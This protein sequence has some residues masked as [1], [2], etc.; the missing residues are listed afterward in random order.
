MQTVDPIKPVRPTPSPP[1]PR[2][3]VSSRTLDGVSRARPAPPA[4]PQPL[5]MTGARFTKL[6]STPKKPHTRDI[7]IAVCASPLLLLLAATDLIGIAVVVVCSVAAVALRLGS[8]V[9][10]VFALTAF[11]YMFSLQVLGVA[12][13]AQTEAAIAYILLTAGAVSLALE[14]RHSQLMWPK[15]SKNKSPQ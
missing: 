8:K 9:T 11:M 7:I 4:K 5:P 13:W 2:E 3:E 10:F 14:T 15:N 12:A 6:K 1:R